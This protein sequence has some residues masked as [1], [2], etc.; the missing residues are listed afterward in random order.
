MIFEHEW[1]M[2][3]IKVKYMYIYIYIY[4]H[5]YIY[6]R[7]IYSADWKIIFRRVRKLAEG[8]YWLRHICPSVC[9]YACN[10]SA[11]N[12][13]ILNTLYVL[14]FLQNLSGKFEID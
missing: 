9:M 14:I 11:P 6:T 12:R 10:I 7:Y 4:I 5:I 3:V 8:D 13:S 2:S 1:G